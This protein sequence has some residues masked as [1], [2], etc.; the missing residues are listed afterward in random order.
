MLLDHD[1]LKIFR[2]ELRLFMPDAAPRGASWIT[3]I[4]ASA[5]D[6]TPLGTA[7]V[8]DDR[9]VLTSAHVVK[10][11]DEV[12]SE[13]WMAFP[14]S[15]N[16]PFARRRVID[17]RL[18]EHQMADLAVME[19]GEPVPSGVMAAR[20]RC[21]RPADLV[22]RS[23]WAFG[24]TLNDP[25][26]NAT[27]GTVGASL[28]YG[29][30][31]LDADSRYHVDPGFSGGGLWCPDYGAIVGIVGQANDR[32]DGRAITLHLAD[33][34]L[35]AEKIRL[36]TPWTVAARFVARGPG[37]NAHGAAIGCAAHPCPHPAQHQLCGEHDRNLSQPLPQR[38][39]LAERDDGAA[40]VRRRHG[41]SRQ[42]VPPSQRSPTPT[43]AANRSRT[44]CRGR[45]CQSQRAQSH[46]QRRL[47]ITGP[48]PK[49]YEVRDILE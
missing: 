3:A 9:R 7:V 37:R 8:I 12:R 48:S 20:L 1:G 14:M 30:V 2:T 35:P 42:A 41:R 31:R 17:V 19:L 13:L 34:Y 24:F 40:L 27:N 39:T 21:P 49:I 26:S 38:Q 47:I 23:W 18:A 43:G 33:G 15:E 32:G 16:L 22:N 11:G 4:H 28:G 5:T 46:Q 6:F 25:Q 44:A 36:L 10:V 45:K 29:W